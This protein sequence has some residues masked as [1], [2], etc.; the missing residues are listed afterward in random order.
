ML[1]FLG[2]WLLLTIACGMIGCCWL[3]CWQ[4]ESFNRQGDRIIAAEGLGLVTIAI[5]LLIASFWVPLSP[6][7]GIAIAGL[8]IGLALLL[9]ATRREIARII[10]HSHRGIY[11]QFLLILAIAAQ[12][13]SGQ[14]TWID[15]GL[16]HYGMMRWL[17]DYGAVPGVGLIDS[18]MGWPSAWFAFAAPF[19]PEIAQTQGTAVANGFL[20]V[21]AIA[22]WW[23]GWR[24]LLKQDAQLSDW[25]AIFIYP[26]L[27]GLFVYG[28]LYPGTLRF[29]WTFINIIMSASNDFV[30]MMLT[31]LVSWSILA[32]A[33][34]KPSSVGD[35]SDFGSYLVPFFLGTGACA[36]KLSALPLIPV[37]GLFY[38]TPRPW[39]WR[40]LL[41]LG[42]IL[43]AFLLPYMAFG[44]VT[45]GC[46]L[47]PARAFCWDLPWTAALPSDVEKS[48]G[49]QEGGWTA[50]YDEP[51]SNTFYWF[52]AFRNWFESA[53]LL[54]LST[55]LSLIG[56]LLG[57]MMA[58][59]NK[60]LLKSDRYGQIWVVLVAIAGLSFVLW[61]SP[62]LRFGWGYSVVIPALVF[63]S[64]CHWHHWRILPKSN[65]ILGIS[66]KMWQK[67]MKFIFYGIFAL[68]I[69]QS[70][71]NSWFLMPRPLL[72]VKVA[73]A[74]VNDVQYYYPIE[75]AFYSREMLCW[76]APIPCAEY[77]EPQQ[78]NVK[79][80][81]PER[82]ISGGFVRADY[83]S[84]D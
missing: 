57:I 83:E 16:Y 4:V 61:R 32:I 1:Y 9:P 41:G 39:R 64:W 23:L 36:M 5:A 28:R 71:A 68:L 3:N 45:S 59:R 78:N 13:M 14:I 19:N 72:T 2:A 54:G 65:C 81:R 44:V 17:S 42:L 30:V 18:R 76:G 38:L 63:A 60:N 20:L 25:F 6:W 84:E 47:S 55:G 77:D 56:L 43:A 31:V 73:P 70:V 24:H 8:G 34:G 79:L 53:T 69:F 37:A 7:T 27:L 82:G 80:R 35:R 46:P 22:H 52:W 50:W 74:Q 48:L 49:L 51:S 66:R 26:L 15:T 12:L 11:G 75:R 62:L 58:A 40:R 67:V 33:A 21:I 29:A 10:S